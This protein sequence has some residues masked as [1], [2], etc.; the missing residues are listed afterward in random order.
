M[1]KSSC[2][3]ETHPKL[4]TRNTLSMIHITCDKIMTVS[5]L[6]INFGFLIMINLTLSA[7]RFR[8]ANIVMHRGTSAV[9]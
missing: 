2:I 7:N 5:Q 8:A 3:H 6:C 1:K 9:D 4:V